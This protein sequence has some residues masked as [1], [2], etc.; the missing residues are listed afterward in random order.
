MSVNFKVILFRVPTGITGDTQSL[1]TQG[2]VTY[3]GTNDKGLG[4][5]WGGPRAG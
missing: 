3:Q 1:V 2:G 5:F 4:K